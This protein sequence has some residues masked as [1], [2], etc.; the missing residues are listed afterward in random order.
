MA[1]DVGMS[2][3]EREFELEMQDLGGPMTERSMEQEL[4]AMLQDAETDLVGTAAEAA[5]DSP[6]AERLFELTQRE[7]ESESELERQLDPILEQAEYEHFWGSLKK[8]LN[9]R[10]LRKLVGAGIKLAGGQIPAFQALKGAT[11]LLRG[12]TRGLLKQ[13]VKAGLGTA[14]PGA[15]PFLPAA[16]SALGFEATEDPGENREAWDNLAGVVRETYEHL[17]EN[18]TDEVDDPLE[19]SR[20]S[21]QALQAALRRA[22]S[23]GFGRR[24]AYRPGTRVVHVRPGQQLLIRVERS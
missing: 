12:N 18:V 22:Q 6:Y 14:I 16:L 15:G 17:A 23:R 5:P 20:L 1:D 10:R 9:P 4:E 24:R 7:W 3:L 13:L 2:E 21:N 11:Q 8:A 19:A